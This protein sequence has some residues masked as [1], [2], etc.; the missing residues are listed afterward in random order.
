M[1]T[2]PCGILQR[3]LV[4]ALAL[5]LATAGGCGKSVTTGLCIRPTEVDLPLWFTQPPP[6]SQPDVPASLNLSLPLH[7][8]PL[9]NEFHLPGWVVYGVVRSIG[10]REFVA[11]GTFRSFSV[12]DEKGES[13]VVIDDLFYDV[14]MDQARQVL[15]SIAAE[16]AAAETER[17]RL[18]VLGSFVRRRFGGLILFSLN[19]QTDMKTNLLLTSGKSTDPIETFSKGNPD[20]MPEI[21]WKETG[22]YT[23]TTMVGP[24]H[25]GNA[26]LAFRR[27][28]EE[29][30]RDLAK[31]LMFKYSHMNKNFIEGGI[32]VSDDVKEEVYKEDIT[33][34][35]RG[36]IVRRRV[37][38][39]ERGL[40]LVE[41]CVPVGGVARQ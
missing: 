25:Y 6:E 36:V 37:V 23:V 20:K 41:V 8:Q 9:A 16:C 31:G 7:L 13:Q 24:F 38:D 17:E 4:L 35:M 14:P 15:A 11:N 12:V 32:N 34:R 29:A 28:E 26:E 5:A 27:T 21:G 18:D 22:G 39:M 1:G 10:A 33:L 3:A 2:K 19:R 40:C 30:I